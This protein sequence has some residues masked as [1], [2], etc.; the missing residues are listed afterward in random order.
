MELR[1]K[2]TTSAGN[3]NLDCPLTTNRIVAEPPIRQVD[4]IALLCGLLSLADPA[5]GITTR[6]NTSRCVIKHCHNRHAH[7]NIDNNRGRNTAR[8]E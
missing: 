7:Y 2:P 3:R 6:V 1:Q 4:Y 8:I 5:V